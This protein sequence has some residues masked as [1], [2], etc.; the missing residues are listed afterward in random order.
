MYAFILTFYYYSKL[1]ALSY[2]ILKCCETGTYYAV[3][4][5][6]TENT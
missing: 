4:S 5:E 6:I 3:S 2:I 1:A